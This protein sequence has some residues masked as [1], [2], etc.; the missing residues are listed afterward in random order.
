VRLERQDIRSK[1]PDG[2]FDLN[3]C[4]K[5]AFTYFDDVAQAQITNAIANRLHEGGVLIVG[6]RERLPEGTMTLQPFT[7]QQ[8]LYTKH[9]GPLAASVG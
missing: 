7:S 6:R 8:C 2:P 3:L 5:L 4:R 9:A 1:R